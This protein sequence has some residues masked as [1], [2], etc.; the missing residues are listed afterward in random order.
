MNLTPTPTFIFSLISRS[1]FYLFSAVAFGALLSVHVATA[2]DFTPQ[3]RLAPSDGIP[4]QNLSSNLQISGDTAVA[5]GST[6]AYVYVRAGTTWVEQTKLVPSDGL[7]VFGDAFSA[8]VAI[9]GDT[10]VIGGRN[11]TINSNPNQGAVYVFIRSGGIWT[12]QRLIAGDGAASDFFGYSVSVSGGTMVV[13]T[14]ND[15]VGANVDQGSA[16][17]FVRSGNVWSE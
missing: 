8:S 17:I 4:N 7:G 3:A 1:S 10:I 12:Q 5:L 14:P 9:S 16:Y 6:G 13:G 15:D 11:A 2:A